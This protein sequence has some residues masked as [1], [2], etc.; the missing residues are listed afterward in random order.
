MNE[1]KFWR[2]ALE[3]LEV[4]KDIILII[5]IQRIGSAPNK[6]GAKMLV[7]ADTL[8]GT[9]GG[10]I[11]EH[12]LIEQ[13]RIVLEKG[14]PK[15]D[16]V[17]LDHS[18]GNQE[19]HSGMICSGSQTFALILLKKEDITRIKILHEAFTKAIP[20]VLAL[21]AE[22]LSYSTE[23]ILKEDNF[24]TKSEDDWEYKENIGIQNK[25]FVIGG[26]HVSLALSRIMETLD[27]HITI[28]DDRQ[29][30][31]T[32]QSNSYAHEKH[33]I[34][35]ENILSYVPEGE[36]VFVTIMT[37]GH[38]SDELVLEKLIARNYRYIGMMAS[39][40]KKEQAFAG[41]ENKGISEEL[42]SSVHS[43]IGLKIKSDT[44]EEIAVSI[45]AEIIAVKNKN[46]EK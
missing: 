41:L 16:T 45:A 6:P 42:L 22:G 44:P 33:V 32:M 14:I 40:F 4:G 5:M 15:V 23:E 7:S 27:F 18:E 1:E 13:A 39:V 10:G 11:A 9:V 25:L 3:F 38:S 37:Y 21:T 30:L 12:R 28:L 36:N 29:D 35:Y 8:I 24:Y 2:T 46:K 17:F 31:P 19:H 20:G 26:G 43:P 34:S